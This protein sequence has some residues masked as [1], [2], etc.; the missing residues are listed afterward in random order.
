M[1]RIFTVESA[2]ETLQII[3]PIVEEMLAVRQEI[4]TIQPQAWS[5]I[6]KH[7]GNGGSYPASIL[8]DEFQKLDRLVHHIQALGVEVKDLNTGLLDFRALRDGR[9]V[10]LCWKHG[11]GEIAY[12]HELDGGFAGRKPLD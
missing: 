6:E 8:V 10:Y 12:W 9:E 2:N 1:T 3:R 7:A 4:L 11:E 5:A